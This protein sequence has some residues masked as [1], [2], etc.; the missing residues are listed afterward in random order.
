MIS[1]F[2]V[3]KIDARL[4]EAFDRLLPQLSASLVTPSTE[5][6]QRMV[7]APSMRLMAAQCGQQ[8]VGM[9]SLVWYDVPSGRHAWIED[10]VV[11]A[12]QRRDGVGEALVRAAVECARHE[13]CDKISLT[14][15]ASRAAAHALYR[16]VGFERYDT[17]LF[18]LKIDTI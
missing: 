9:L 13:K 5:T 11:D 8:I 15:H 6:L 2:T 17:T 14:S 12:A 18:R 7:C 10:V 1:V 3:D 16:K 4:I